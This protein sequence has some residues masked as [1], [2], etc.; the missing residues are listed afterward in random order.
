MVVRCR[1]LNS[2]EVLRSCGAG[3]SGGGG[4]DE[5][6]LGWVAV[7]GLMLFFF[8]EFLFAATCCCHDIGLYH[9]DGR[10]GAGRGQSAACR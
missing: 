9:I 6:E 8:F 3:L 7:V 2:R 10:V 5:G 4:G 1:P